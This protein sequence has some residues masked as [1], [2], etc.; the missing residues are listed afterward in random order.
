M[1]E[2]ERHYPQVFKFAMVALMGFSVYIFIYSSDYMIKLYCIVMFFAV[3]NGWAASE[4]TRFKYGDLYLLIDAICAAMYFM[5][6]LELYEGFYTYF[7]LYS[8]ITFIMYWIWN[9]LLI[10][11]NVQTAKNLKVYNRC[12]MFACI[13]SFGIFFVMTFIK[14]SA[15]MEPLQF[16]G[17]ILWIGLLC[18]WYIDFYIKSF[19]N[20]DA[21]SKELSSVKRGKS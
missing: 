6:L 12:D 1:N 17:M 4:D 15:I 16:F 18:K 9:K 13:C 11:E 19:I 5:A 14:D 7:W 21:H 20:K 3:L 10:I 2:N 8:G